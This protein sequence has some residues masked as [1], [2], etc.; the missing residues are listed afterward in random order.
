MMKGTPTKP[1]FL[2]IL[3][4]QITPFLLGAYGH[5]VVQTPHLNRLVE[6]GVRF[7]AAYTPCPCCVPAR[8]SFMTGRSAS[9]IGCYDNGDS[10]PSLVPTFAHY[11]TNA[12][13]ETVLS[14]KMHFIGADQLHGFR[15]RL[16]TDVYPSTYDWTYEEPRANAEGMAFDFPSQYQG[17]GVGPGWVLELQFDEENA[18]RSLEFLRA[19]HDEP[20][21]LVTSFTSPHP[22]FIAPKEFWDLYEGAPIDVPAFP[23]NMAETYSAMDRALNKWHGLDTIRDVVSAESIARM[24]HGYY[25]LLS[26]VDSKVGKLL[27]VLDEQGL[28]DNTVIIFS[29]DH[30]DML[31]EKGMIQ[32]RSF[33]EWSSRIPLILSGPGIPAGKRLDT[34]VSL[35]DLAPTML[36]CAGIGEDMRLPMEG[37]SLLALV[38]GTDDGADRMAISEYHGEGPFRACFMIR[39]GRFKYT[40][41]QDANPQ[42]FD[43][44]ADP[45]EWRNLAG[46]PEYKDIEKEL[47]DI[48]VTTFDTDGIQPEIQRRLQ[49]KKIILPAMHRNGTHWDYQPFFDASKQYVRSDATKNYA[50]T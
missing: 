24:R 22:P 4:D 14:G 15:R 19:E 20:F 2:V 32:K 26:Y 49:C 29:G 44:V 1:N 42:L 33:Y 21:C 17:D 13:Y 5:N 28:S 37:E 34:P 40:N 9:L 38:D 50:R 46:Q 12:G 6:R 7:D 10:F 30:G 48:I 27:D 43:V 8:S 41:I 3:A 35:I 31:G 47:H 16:T 23:D 36:D 11:L 18:F 45:G 39:R 25:A